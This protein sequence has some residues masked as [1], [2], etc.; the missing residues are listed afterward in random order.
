MFILQQTCLAYRLT[1]PGYGRLSV[2]PDGSLHWEFIE[3]DIS[4]CKRMTLGGDL[5][6]P[7]MVVQK[8]QGEYVPR[9]TLR[10]E[11]FYSPRTVGSA[12]G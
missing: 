1:E 6:C 5:N 7:T 9:V 12:S 10:D 2:L 11:A 4:P 8:S 3:V